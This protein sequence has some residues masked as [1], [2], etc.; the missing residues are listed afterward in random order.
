MLTQI[1]LPNEILYVWPSRFTLVKVCFFINR[2]VTL[3]IMAFLVACSFSTT[4]TEH[5]DKFHL[6]QVRLCGGTFILTSKFTGLRPLWIP[7]FIGLHTRTQ[8]ILFSLLLGMKSRVLTFDSHFS[9]NATFLFHFCWFSTDPR[10]HVLQLQAGPACISSLPRPSACLLL[11]H[12]RRLGT[13]Y[14]ASCSEHQEQGCV[15]YPP[16]FLI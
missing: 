4:L 11:P 10:L 1:T 3:I 5:C 9:Y 15:I 6:F 14:R 8:F 2:Y 12:L 7:P 16:Q 13:G